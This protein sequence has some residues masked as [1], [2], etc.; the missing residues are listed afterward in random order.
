MVFSVIPLPAISLIPCTGKGKER[1]E[2]EKGNPLELN[3][4]KMVPKV[5]ACRQSAWNSN[6]HDF[7]EWKD[8]FSKAHFPVGYQKFVSFLCKSRADEIQYF[9]LHTEKSVSIH[10]SCLS[11]KGNFLEVLKID[12]IISW[13]DMTCRYG[14]WKEFGYGGHIPIKHS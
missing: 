10:C 7:A 5:K 1:K 2:I 13:K 9:F 14:I 8:V 4:T 6:P 3:G 11:W 12:E